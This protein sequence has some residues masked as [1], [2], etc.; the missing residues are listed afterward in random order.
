MLLAMALPI[1]KSAEQMG[2]FRAIHL[3]ISRLLFTICGVSLSNMHTNLL[4]HLFYQG[5]FAAAF[6]A[7]R[8]SSWHCPVKR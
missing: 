8:S 6:A 7:P 4:E 3:V 1:I 2:L 5:P